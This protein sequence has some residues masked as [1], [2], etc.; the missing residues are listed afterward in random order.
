[1]KISLL[2]GNFFQ[3]N[4]EQ[5]TASE[6]KPLYFICLIGESLEISAQFLNV[7]SQLTLEISGFV[8]VDDVDLGQFVQ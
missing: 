2:E 7:Q 6:R 5:K 8:L 3:S 1:M 4:I